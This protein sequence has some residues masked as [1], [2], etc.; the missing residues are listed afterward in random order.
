M[1]LY[2]RL[3]QPNLYQVIAYDPGGTIG[4]AQLLIDF[5]A[6]TRPK[7]KLLANLL[8]W[9]SG[10]LSGNE[11]QQQDE[12]VRF[13]KHFHYV[14]GR[15][16]KTDVIGEDFDLVQTIGGADLLSPVRINAVMK[17]ECFKIGVPFHLQKRHLRSKVTKERLRLWGFA[18]TFRK[19]EFAAMQHA[20][21]WARS[22]K[23]ES[24]SRPWKL[25]N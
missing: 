10:E 19:D 4:W 24:R 5:H 23:L 16:V 21:Y 14:N 6:F 11:M 12:L 7:N 13:I 20:M 18:D 1:N 8:Y 22:R 9:N 25:L 17:W 3:A 15:R 2:N